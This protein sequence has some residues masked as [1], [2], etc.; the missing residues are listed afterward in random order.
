MH[1]VLGSYDLAIDRFER[2]IASGAHP[3]FQ[4]RARHNI[5]LLKKKL[6]RQR[7]GSLGVDHWTRTWDTK[8]LPE[9]P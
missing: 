2:F 3:E 7:T 4:P 9:T 8:W 6:A 5:K 1:E